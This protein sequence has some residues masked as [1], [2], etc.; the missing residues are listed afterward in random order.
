MKSVFP[1]PGGKNLAVR[2]IQVDEAAGWV[3]IEVA[4][5]QRS[6]QCPLCGQGS[7]AVHSKYCRR[8]SDLPWG[9]WRVELHLEVHKYFCK[10]PSC[11]RRIFTELL[12]AVTRADDG[13]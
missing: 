11:P 10:K 7:R 1:L 3:K 8:L 9:G 4:S 12:A 13:Q 6:G 2:Q 5:V